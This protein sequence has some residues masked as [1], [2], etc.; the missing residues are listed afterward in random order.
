MGETLPDHLI[1]W[2]GYRFAFAERAAAG[3]V[4][5]VPFFEGESALQTYGRVHLQPRGAGDMLQ[6]IQNILLPNP[7]KLG[8]FPQVQGTFLEGF[9]DLLPQGLRLVVAIGLRS[10]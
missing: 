5:T 2:R 4:Q 7:E 10:H 8:N 6:V 1:P 3:G 9:G